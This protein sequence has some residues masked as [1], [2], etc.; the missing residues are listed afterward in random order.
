MN[1]GNI[2][3]KALK[4]ARRLWL[5]SLD[6]LHGQSNQARNASLLDSPPKR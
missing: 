2:V 3:G 1:Q 5:A 6:N 4:A